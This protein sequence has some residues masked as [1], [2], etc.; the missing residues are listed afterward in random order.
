M[1][2]EI[3]NLTKAQDKLRQW[4]NTRSITI[5]TELMEER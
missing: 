4:N 5:T 2:G 3:T 1:R